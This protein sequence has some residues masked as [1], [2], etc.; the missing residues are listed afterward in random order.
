MVKSSGLNVL[1]DFNDV[2]GDVS[3]HFI[4]DYFIF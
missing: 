2:W 4:T 3:P 1:L